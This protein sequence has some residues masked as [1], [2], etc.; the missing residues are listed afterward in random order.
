MLAWP[1]R[2]WAPQECRERIALRRQQLGRHRRRRR[3]AEVPAARPYQH[4]PG[5]RR[6]HGRD[7]VEPGAASLLPR[8]P[9]ARRR[10][11]RPVRR[12]HVLLARRSR[13]VRVAAEPRR[14]GRDQPAHRKIIWRTKV[15]GNRADHMAISPDGRHVLV[16]PR[17]QGHRRDRHEDGRDRGPHPERRPAAREQ[18]LEGRKARSTTPASAR[19]TRPW[20]SRPS[21]ATKGERVFEIVDASNGSRCC[22]GSTWARSS[23]S[24]ASRT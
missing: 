23:T 10:G 4:H 3:P 8:D 7:S 2:R 12:R 22:A 15:D 21:T 11:A 19:S 9:A 20:T 16:S 6:A 5:H 13:A 1:S 14:R 17:R 18:L 24:S